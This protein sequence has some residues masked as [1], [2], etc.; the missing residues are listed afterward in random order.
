MADP[1]HDDQRGSGYPRVQGLSNGQRSANVPVTEQQQGGHGTVP[2]MLLRS[3][4]A[5]DHVM[6]RNPAR[7]DARTLAANLVT[8]RAG[9]DWENID[10]RMASMN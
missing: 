4:S 10:D 7:R 8:A 2:S 3:A 9:A 6:A 5:D 1:G